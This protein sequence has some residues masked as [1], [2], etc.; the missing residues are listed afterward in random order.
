METGRSHLRTGHGCLQM[1]RFN[2]R[3]GWYSKQ[4]KRY[5]ECLICGEIELIKINFTMC[6]VSNL[7]HSFFSLLYP[8][9]NPEGRLSLSSLRTQRTIHL[10]QYHGRRLFRFCDNRARMFNIQ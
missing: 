7:V 6:T 1:T 9:F 10:S 3:M 5:S 2:C 8:S 4:V